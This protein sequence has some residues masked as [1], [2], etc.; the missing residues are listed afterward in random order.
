MSNFD[1]L[2]EKFNRINFTEMNDVALTRWVRSNMP[3]SRITL[4][5]S[6]TLVKVIRTAYNI[7]VVRGKAVK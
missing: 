5:E 2:A 3:N 1:Y 6:I 7:G 4:A